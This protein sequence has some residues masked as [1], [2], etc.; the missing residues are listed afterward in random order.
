MFLAIEEMR[1]NKLRYGLIFGLL[2]LVAYLV[3][4]LT[5]LAYG[6]MQQNRVA[7][8]KWEAQTI[9]LSKEANKLLA[10]SRF[11]PELAD[12]VEADQ[13]ALLFFKGGVAWGSHQEDDEDKERVSIFGVNQ[14]DFLMPQLT[15]G[16]AFEKAGEVV[17]ADSLL[18]ALEL[19]VGDELVLGEI[20]EPLTIV[21][22][23]DRAYYGVAP[24]VYMA[25]AD[26][27]S[28]LQG[29]LPAPV[30]SAIV[31]KGDLTHY[32]EEELEALAMADFIEKLPG[33]TAQNL[34]FAFMIGFLVVIS[35]VIIGIFIYVLTTQ[36]APIF[37]LMKIQ[38]LSTP[39]IAG[40]IFAQ[41]LLLTGAGTAMGLALTYGSS[42]VLPGAVPFENNWFFYG[43]IG[44]ALVGF[45]L[46]G[47][48]FSVGSIV[49][50]D[51]LKH[52]G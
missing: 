21:G 40:S 17:V 12:E 47:A 20:E 49:K 39:Y 8:D 5:G 43:T 9:L 35:A 14:G 44:L 13:A 30:A 19:S 3:F 16:R 23:T 28:L 38:G 41:T 37:G 42:L 32:P 27:T 15:Q 51:P 10:P 6:L 22:A 45:A 26:F 7:I 48:S 52:I 4:F 11:A 29:E 31:V 18:E 50:V 24:V 36:K 25:E 1:Q 33:Y 34:T 2:V 46:L